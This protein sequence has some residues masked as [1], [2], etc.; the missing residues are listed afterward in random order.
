ME[1]PVPTLLQFYPLQPNLLLSNPIKLFIDIPPESLCSSQPRKHVGE[2]R[3]S[4][5]TC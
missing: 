2:E 4:A 1:I 3:D 5:E